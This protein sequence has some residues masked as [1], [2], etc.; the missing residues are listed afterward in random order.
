MQVMGRRTSLR[1]SRSS[2][3]VDRAPSLDLSTEEFQRYAGTWVYVRHGHVVASA[4][5]HE[6]LTQY[7]DREQYDAVFFVPPTA[8]NLYL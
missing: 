3:V 6:E 1:R 8:A 7:P 5:T 4:K 2:M